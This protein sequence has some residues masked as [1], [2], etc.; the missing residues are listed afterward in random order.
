V[1]GNVCHLYYF[2]RE[3]LEGCKKAI[4]IRALSPGWRDGFQARLEKAGIA[5]DRRAEEKDEMCC[6][7]TGQ[8][9]LEGDQSG[10]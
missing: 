3:N 6:G 8:E 9:V 4:R 2:A 1:S 5:L 10:G 7:A